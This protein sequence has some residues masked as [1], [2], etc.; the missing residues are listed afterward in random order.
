RSDASPSTPPAEET[1][2][3]QAP[4]PVA[5]EA[6]APAAEADE[7]GEPETSEETAPEPVVE[8]VSAP[9]AEAAESEEPEASADDPNGEEAGQEGESVSE[10]PD[11]PDD[12]D[13]ASGEDE[14][15]GEPGQD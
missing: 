5:E 9:A 7:S 10:R 2:E 11:S 12:V 13:E 4:E 8:E 1:S 15:A 6:T 3:V 14:Q